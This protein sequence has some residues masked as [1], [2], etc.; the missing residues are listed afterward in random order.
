MA[1]DTSLP[2][3]RHLARIF[4]FASLPETDRAAL[5]RCAGFVRLG[6]GEHLYL[7][8]D[9]ATAFYAV[10]EGR[11]KIYRTTPSGDEL[12]VHLQGEG[13]LVAEAAIFDLRRYPASCQAVEDSLL[14]RIDSR[15]YIECLRGHPDLSLRIMH[16][17][18]RR[19]RE[20][21]SALESLSLR[22]VKSR[23]A[24]FLLSEAVEDGSGALRCV[25]PVSKRELASML[26]TI[27]ET[28][29]RTL[30]GFKDQGWVEEDES[31]IVLTKPSALRR[32]SG[33][34]K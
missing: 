21:V 32:L 3:T 6:R 10:L 20:F 30:R 22:D 25:I 27:P 19:L 13:D 15:G 5:A 9:D 24:S 1:V 18:S 34:S 2:L 17:Y 11:V 23:L 29:S 31:G 14:L 8:G 4:L 33:S 28:L 12:I 7:E 26:G 16:A